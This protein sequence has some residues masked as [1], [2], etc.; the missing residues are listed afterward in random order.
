MKK[1]SNIVKAFL[2][3]AML[4]VTFTSMAVTKVYA[5]RSTYLSDMLYTFDGK[6]LYRGNS[7]YRSDIL[8]TWDGKYL[9]CGNSTYMS[10]ILYT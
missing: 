1:S 5:G 6:Y 8:Y 10:D 2:V 4:C 9:Y 7:T 3:L